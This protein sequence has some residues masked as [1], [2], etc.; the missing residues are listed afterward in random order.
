MRLRTLGVHPEIIEQVATCMR[1]G[2][3]IW[4]QNGRFSFEEQLPDSHVGVGGDRAF[5]FLVEASDG[6]AMD[7][8][9][10]DPAT[11]RLATW[12]GEAWALGQNALLQQHTLA[13]SAPLVWRT[14]PAWLNA[15]RRGLVVIRLQVAV[16]HLRGANTLIAEDVP[17]GRQLKRLSGAN[18]SRIMVPANLMGSGA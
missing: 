12:L 6:Q 17:H 16:L 7:I 1:V 4:L 11:G 14:V 8:V 5:L 9:A 10:W 13:D 2:R 18:G 15:G 3:V